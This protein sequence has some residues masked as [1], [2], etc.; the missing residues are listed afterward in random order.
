MCTVEYVNKIKFLVKTGIYEP[1]ANSYYKISYDLISNM[2]GKEGKS[3]CSM[4]YN[5]PMPP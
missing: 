5:L 4:G 2:S 3:I 1:L